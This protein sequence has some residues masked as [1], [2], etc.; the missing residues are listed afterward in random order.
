MEPILSIIV[1]VYNHEKYVVQ[2]LESIQEQNIKYLFEV[3]IFR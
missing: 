3:I 2:A 1:P